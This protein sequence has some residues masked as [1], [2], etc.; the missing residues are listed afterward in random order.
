MSFLWLQSV[1]AAAKVPCQMR[2]QTI[3]PRNLGSRND[4]VASGVA[5]ARRSDYA[6]LPFMRATVILT[7]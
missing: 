4:L 3:A 7:G 1:P 5:Y 2:D 6:C